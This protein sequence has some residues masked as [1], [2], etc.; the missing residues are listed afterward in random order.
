MTDE[1]TTTAS[2]EPSLPAL[3]AR[4][5]AQFSDPKWDRDRS[6]WLEGIYE[7]GLPQCTGEWIGGSG[8]HRK[9]GPYCGKLATYAD[10]D[11]CYNYCDEHLNAGDRELGVPVEVPWAGLIRKAGA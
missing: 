1:D 3:Q 10:W 4:F 6:E 11:G 2:L 8:G 9:H 5:M 7:F